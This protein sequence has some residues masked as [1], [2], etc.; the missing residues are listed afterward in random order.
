LLKKISFF[1]IDL[2]GISA[3]WKL[4]SFERIATLHLFIARLL[5]GEVSFPYYVNG[6]SKAYYIFGLYL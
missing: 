2:L 3:N 1:L 5:L 4:P 6:L